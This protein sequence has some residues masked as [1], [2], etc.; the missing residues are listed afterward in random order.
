MPDADGADL[1]AS[2]F[3]L[4]YKFIPHEQQKDKSLLKHLSKSYGA[5]S[6]VNIAS[7]ELIQALSHASTASYHTKSFRGGGTNHI[8]I[9]HKD[10]IVVS[11]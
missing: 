2:V 9:C 11:S 10:K 6:D 5:P 1:P 8:I 7:E 3:P 4:T